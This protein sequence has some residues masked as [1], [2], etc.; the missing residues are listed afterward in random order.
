MPNKCLTETVPVPPT[1]LQATEDKLVM[2]LRN[3]CTEQEDRLLTHLDQKVDSLLRTLY[4]LCVRSDADP[5]NNQLVP[6]QEQQI[7]PAPE[8]Q[9]ALP[10]PAEPPPTGFSPAKKKP[11]PNS[12][13]RNTVPF[14]PPPPPGPQGT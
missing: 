14:G 7:V 8:Q 9:L 13:T 6:A 2:F 1:K 12:P 10:S 4:P 5:P 3:I 11:K